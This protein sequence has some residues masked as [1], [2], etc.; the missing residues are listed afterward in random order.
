MAARGGISS[1]RARLS[2]FGRGG[3]RNCGAATMRS[4][5]AS[6]PCG[7]PTSTSRVR[8]ADC[9][10][11]HSATFIK[12][13]PLAMTRSGQGGSSASL[14]AR[15]RWA[16][17]ARMRGL[18]C[19]QRGRMRSRLSVTGKPTAS[20]SVSTCALSPAFSA[21]RTQIR[22]AVDGVPVKASTR[23]PS[24]KSPSSSSAA[25]EAASPRRQVS[26]QPRCAQSAGLGTSVRA[27]YR[28]A[29]G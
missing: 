7:R 3:S 5:A 14:A 20:T 8:P 4:K 18:P 6:C 11:S 28:R 23:A 16:R 22:G 21:C 9:W 1:G 25:A 19:C 12:R 26:P 24:A 27:N 17:L 2:T 10:R 29:A 15:S 13:R